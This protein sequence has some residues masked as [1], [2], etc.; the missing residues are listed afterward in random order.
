[1]Q[2]AVNYD[3]I[4]CS[5]STIQ[6]AWALIYGAP[7]AMQDTDIAQSN[8][9]FLLGKKSYLDLKLDPVIL[10]I[11]KAEGT[12]VAPFWTTQMSWSKNSKLVRLGPQYLSYHRLTDPTDESNRYNSYKSDVAP[13]LRSW[14][15]TYRDTFTE[16]ASIQKVESV[17]FGYLN[18]FHFKTD[19]NFNVEQ[20]FNFA[21]AMDAK[22]DPKSSALKSFSSSVN[23]TE[24]A[25]N[26]GLMNL[27]LD[28][29]AE[30]NSD[31]MIRI[32]TNSQVSI[33]LKSFTSFADIS[34]IKD[35]VRSAQKRAKRLF[36]D[37]ITDKTFSDEMG[38]K[39]AK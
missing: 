27:S 11:Q 14:L 28:L 36:F 5:K 10:T 33:T 34:L 29:R 37:F 32:D 12:N 20:F 8:G 31:Q 19:A 26:L 23:F 21:L 13:Y 1:M 22:F 24:P 3:K 17:F 18:R 35:S 2:S 39:F 6:E 25:G 38:G 15:E 7:Y 16:N 4:I 9:S 30:I